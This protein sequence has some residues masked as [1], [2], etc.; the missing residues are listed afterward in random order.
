M[1]K[2]QIKGHFGRVG[3]SVL[4]D[5]RIKLRHLKLLLYVSA[6]A[7]D[8]DG[9]KRETIANEAGLGSPSRVSEALG[10]LQD[11]GYVSS[12]IR[13]Y[14]SGWRRG[15]SIRLTDAFFDDDRPT[16]NA[17][18]RG[19]DLGEVKR[20]ANGV[21]HDVRKLGRS[22][23]DTTKY[24]HHNTGAQAREDDDFAELE[25][26]DLQPSHPDW[27]PP[28]SWQ[29]F[30]HGEGLTSER[31]SELTVRFVEWAGRAKRPEQ[32]WRKT[33]ASFV[34]REAGDLTD[35][36]RL[37]AQSQLAPILSPCA[38]FY[39]YKGES[40]WTGSYFEYAESNG[41]ADDRIALEQEKRTAWLL[42]RFPDLDLRPPINMD[43]AQGRIYAHYIAQART[44]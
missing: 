21:G 39:R 2:R 26:S 1:K 30:A 4:R 24:N 19:P 29:A 5:P 6:Q 36:D 40:Y 22:I 43:D 16:P 23:K 9:Y 20:S 33:W 7:D 25:E 10:E 13:T 31:V 11:M 34:Q 3:L 27:S 28:N 37:D 14:K 12:A 18:V 17:D 32:N 15:L 42:E 35:Q 44:T 38:C 8:F 41:L